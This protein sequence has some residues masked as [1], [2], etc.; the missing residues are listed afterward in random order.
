MGPKGST[1][2]RD[3]TAFLRNNVRRIGADNKLLL[4][5]YFHLIFIR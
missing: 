2:I 1:G 4:E 5:G 3:S